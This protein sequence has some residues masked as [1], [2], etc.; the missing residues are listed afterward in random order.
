MAAADN[1]SWRGHES[2]DWLCR[3][4]LPYASAHGFQCGRGRELVFSHL[5]ACNG[6]F[7]SKELIVSGS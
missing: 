2:K 4:S 1:T 7:V 6:P 5:I 3:H